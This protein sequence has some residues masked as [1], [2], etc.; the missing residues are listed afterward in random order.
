MVVTSPGR[1]SHAAVSPHRSATSRRTPQ[2]YVIQSPVGPA[3]AHF[4]VCA[5]A[6]GAAAAKFFICHGRLEYMYRS[7]HGISPP[8]ASCLRMPA[9][10]PPSHQS[11]VAQS[12]S[13]YVAVPG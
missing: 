12:P 9:A 1:A 11:P 3:L 8:A 2:N 13:T 5:A 6:A 7:Q 4:G 10:Q